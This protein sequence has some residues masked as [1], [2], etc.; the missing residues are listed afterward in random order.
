MNIRKLDADRSFMISMAS[1]NTVLKLD[2]EFVKW[3][4]PLLFAGSSSSHGAEF[5][6]YKHCNS[7]RPRTL[8]INGS[9][10]W[11]RPVYALAQRNQCNGDDSA[12]QSKKEA[13]FLIGKEQEATCGYTLYPRGTSCTL[14]APS[15]TT[16]YRDRPRHSRPHSP[17]MQQQFT[18]QKLRRLIP[19][20]KDPPLYQL[21]PPSTTDLR[22]DLPMHSIALTRSGDPRH[23]TP[24][25]Q[26]HGG[27]TARVASLRGQAHSD[28][29]PLGDA[30]HNDSR[31]PCELWQCNHG[32]CTLY[33]HPY[34]TGNQTPSE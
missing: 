20:G 9:E 31:S 8:F 30:H 14:D 29:L 22:H 34:P 6:N 24:R 18:L 7:M 10:G 19:H 33:S 11:I 2:S 3:F 32:L 27:K 5:A 25:Y 15:N 21:D 17:R 1:I 23:K 26:S 13:N 4:M 16:L 28:H 12:S